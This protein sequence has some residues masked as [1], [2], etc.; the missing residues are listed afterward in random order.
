M[1][2]NTTFSIFACPRESLV[3]HGPIRQSIV[4]FLSFTA[5]VLTFLG[6][7]LLA[8]AAEPQAAANNAPQP[9]LVTSLLQSLD[10]DSRV[11]LAAARTLAEQ[12][13]SSSLVAQAVEQVQAAWLESQSEQWTFNAI[14]V[15]EQWSAEHAVAGEL[16]IRLL[17]DERTP[18]R[19]AALQA[20]AKA[21][22]VSNPRILPL[23]ASL[24]YAEPQQRYRAAGFLGKFG[25]QAAPAVGALVRAAQNDTSHAALRWEA[26]FALRDI[27][28]AGVPGLIEVLNTTDRS[29]AYKTLDSLQSLGEKAE[30]AYQA[31]LQKLTADDPHIR[32]RAVS[33]MGRLPSHARQS[34]PPIEQML[35]DPDQ[36]VRDAAA[37]AIDRLQQPSADSAIRRPAPD[38]E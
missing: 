16:L 19:Q 25:E 32:W 2:R 14:R 8:H 23:I 30:P 6:F 22:V 26:V 9:A 12:Q 1:S 24:R 17:E 35:H 29:V 27:G 18:I 38:F 4:L 20:A 10:Q 13:D 31:V 3:L 36:H 15:L 7:A 21:G 5:L 11:A 28:P 34:L 37:E 33:V